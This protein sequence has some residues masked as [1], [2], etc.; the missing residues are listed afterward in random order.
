MF[1][2]NDHVES[3]EDAEFDVEGTILEIKEF[4][5]VEKAKI[6]WG[7]G[8]GWFAT[9]GLQMYKEEFEKDFDNDINAYE[10]I[11][12]EIKCAFK[13]FCVDNEI[14]YLYE[15]YEMVT[16]KTFHDVI[17]FTMK[18]GMDDEKTVTVPKDEIA[19]YY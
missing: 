4:S 3:K 12:N 9:E 7:F 17:I 1:K 11:F 14:E 2:V 18:V 10:N 13:R 5:G 19:Y 16:F 6:D 15:N 8:S